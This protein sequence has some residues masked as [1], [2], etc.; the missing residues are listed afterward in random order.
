MEHIGIIY[1]NVGTAEFECQINANVEKTDYIQVNHQ[2]IGAVLGQ[3]DSIER[4]TDLSL[5][6]AKRVANGEPMEIDEKVTARISV[7]GYRDERSLLQAPRTPFKAGEFIYR[8]EDELIRKVIGLK[9]DKEGGA[10]VG[11]LSGHDIKVY[12]DIN[13]LVQKHL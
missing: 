4:R 13:S 7:I 11:L 1:G 8:A 6:K 10:Y 9:E 2:T 12:V 3:V 5:E